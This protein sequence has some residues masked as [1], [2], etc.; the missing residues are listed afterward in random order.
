MRDRSKNA[1]ILLLVFIVVIVLWFIL[2][3][4]HFV[5]FIPVSPAGMIL[6]TLGVI[7]ILYLVLDH[8]LDRSW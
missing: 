8:F 5:V 4:L 2:S 7:V 6:F 3:R 1:S